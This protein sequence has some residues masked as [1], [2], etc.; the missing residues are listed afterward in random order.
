VVEGKALAEKWPSQKRSDKH[1]RS[2]RRSAERQGEYSKL[3]YDY[4]TMHGKATP[5]RDWTV[6]AINC[7]DETETKRIPVAP[8]GVIFN[9]RAESHPEKGGLCPFPAVFLLT[10]RVQWLCQ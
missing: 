2:A 9:A 10:S 1:F 3:V 6:Y 8:Y 4:K 5:G 7:I